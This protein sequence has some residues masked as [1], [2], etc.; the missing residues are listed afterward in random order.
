MG[1]NQYNKFMNEF[2]QPYQVKANVATN[3]GASQQFSYDV[4]AMGGGGGAGGAGGYEANTHLSSLSNCVQRLQTQLNQYLTKIIDEGSEGGGGSNYNLGSGEVLN[5]HL[6][7]QY[8]STPNTASAFS[9]APPPSQQ[10]H[11]HHAPPP[12]PSHPHQAGSHHHHLDAGLGAAAAASSM[13][14]GYSYYS[15][16]PGANYSGYQPS[17]GPPPAPLSHHSVPAAG[18]IPPPP[19]AYGMIP[20]EYYNQQYSHFQEPKV[21]KSKK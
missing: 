7:E 13:N 8:S 5:S 18:G 3:N 6:M 11:S 4:G 10:S 21:K 14:N 12:P 2:Q 19:G 1:D 16:F 9:S 20:P 15:N 17:L